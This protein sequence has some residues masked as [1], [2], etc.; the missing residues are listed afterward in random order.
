MK[1][2]QVAVQLYTLRDHLKTA[3]DYAK[4]LQKVAEIGYQSV[5]ISGPRP[6]PPAEIRKLCDQ[7]G[8]TLN[9]THENSAEIL[10]NPQQ[11]VRNLREFGCKYTAYPYPAGIDFNSEDS[12]NTLIQKLEAS[13]K[14]LA[15]A[16]LVLTYHN[17]HHE[18]RKM[19]DK[20]V[21]ETLYERTHPNHLQGEIDTYW[22]Q[23]GGGDPVGW[24]RK[25]NQRL[26]LL[27][28]KDYMVTPDYK[29]S[30]TEIGNGV[31]DFK[32]IVA[33][34]EASG[35]EW[36]IVEQD[37]CPGDPFESLAKSFAYIRDNLVTA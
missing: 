3:E 33:A 7:Y 21:L 14:V 20:T 27:H 2:N 34:A 16:G 12:V 24:C 30:F 22:V 1:L 4:S 5:Q 9:S 32:A 6:L 18:F 13:G 31:L 26:P 15:E 23:F 8:L 17:H 29:I 36:F 37:V 19:G 10:E 11:I 28:M 35:C 25:L